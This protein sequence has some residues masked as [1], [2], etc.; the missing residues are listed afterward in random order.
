MADAVTMSF[1][2]QAFNGFLRRYATAIQQRADQ[3]VQWAAESTNYEILAGTPV[4]TGDFKAAWR[5][6]SRI[7]PLHWIAAANDSVQAFALEYGSIPGQYPWPNVGP[8]T[9][10]GGGVIGE[11]FSDAAPNIY[12]SQ[13]PIGM[14]RRALAA[15]AP[16]FRKMVLDLVRDSWS[17]P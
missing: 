6:P 7:A 10:H 11:G 4:D 16:V 15:Q 13:A 9:V 5:P 17:R 2:T 8:R 3:E 12:S 1:N 14:V